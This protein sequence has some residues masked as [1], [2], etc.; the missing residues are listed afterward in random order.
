[1][2]ILR[3]RIGPTRTRPPIALPPGNK[4]VAID[5]LNTAVR[6]A[7][8][9]RVGVPPSFSAMPIGSKNRSLTVHGGGRGG[10]RR[11]WDPSDVIGQR[12]SS[13]RNQVA[14]LADPDARK[15]LDAREHLVGCALP[16]AARSPPGRMSSAA[17][18]DSTAKPGLT[19]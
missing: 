3:L 14:K 6:L 10:A 2:I 15:G 13:Q 16:A 4:R 19:A 1:M 12:R 5:S 17:S 7:P 8:R 9:A 11:F 18:A